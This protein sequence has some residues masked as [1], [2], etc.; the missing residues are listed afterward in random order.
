MEV[1]LSGDRSCVL[2]TRLGPATYV[3][4]V[5]HGFGS[6]DGMPPARLAL[7]RLRAEFERRS[8]GDRF[9]RAQARPKAITS[10]LIAAIARVNGDLH[11]RSASH[12]D[13]IT[14]GCSL[15]AALVIDERA[16]LAH[17]GTSAAYLSRDG[18][19]LG[20]TKED[21]FDA[22]GSAVLTRAVGIAPHLEVAVC[23]FTL[24]PGDA[25]VL[26]GQR[27]RDAEDRRRLTERLLF[28]PALASKD[29]VLVVRY[30][31]DDDALAQN[32]RPRLWLVLA[33]GLLATAAF[34]TALCLR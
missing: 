6:I 26:S 5:A 3:F 24:N 13:Y 28:G 4:A 23:N 11:V 31:R 8:R 16:Y 2:S 7:Q 34:Y 1:A 30:D 20:L 32:I 25:L 21:A 15:T 18:Y 14:A 17:V 27:I 33:N 29:D 19:V 9:R 10:A 12:E 22:G